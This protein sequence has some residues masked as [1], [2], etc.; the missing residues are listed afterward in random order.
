MA[1]KLGRPLPEHIDYSTISSLSMEAREKLQRIRPATFGQAARIGGVSAADISNLLLYT[2]V[3]ARS[4]SARSA[5]SE[6][7]GEGRGAALRARGPR[8]APS[9]PHEQPT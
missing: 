7:R 8:G 6:P 3:A 4:G 1:S 2:A 9:A 5:S